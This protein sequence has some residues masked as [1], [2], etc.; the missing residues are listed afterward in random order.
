MKY[1]PYALIVPVMLLLLTALLQ[2]DEIIVRIPAGTNYIKITGDNLK[3][4]KATVIDLGTGDPPIDPGTPPTDKFGLAKFVDTEADKVAKEDDDTRTGLG[5]I[6]QLLGKQI[7]EGK[8]EK[9][10]TAATAA[11]TAVDLFLTRSK[12]KAEWQ[13]FR[14]ALEAKLE[15]LSR[16]GKIKTVA[17]VGQAYEEIAAGLRQGQDE[18]LSPELLELILKI[19]Q[20]VMELLG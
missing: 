5:L 18:F 6:Y 2:A 3:V 4:T 7:K 1:L 10:Q 12:K 11:K 15:G 16:D 13:A 20:L 14:K 17:D 19:I 8:I 9:P